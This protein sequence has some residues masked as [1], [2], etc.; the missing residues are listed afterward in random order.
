MSWACRLSQSALFLHIWPAAAAEL[1]AGA[2]WE[3]GLVG[4]LE[5]GGGTSAREL[6]GRREGGSAHSPQLSVV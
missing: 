2:G 1:V 4:Q 6:E 5:P 3:A